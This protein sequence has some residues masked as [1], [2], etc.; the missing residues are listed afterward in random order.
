MPP[1]FN[2]S[3][4]LPLLPNPLSFTLDGNID[5]PSDNNSWSAGSQNFAIG[6]NTNIV[7]EVRPISE[8]SNLNVLP[9]PLD[10]AKRK[11]LPLWIRYA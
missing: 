9:Q 2:Q 5:N 6:L 1:N 4:K 8:S 3:N 7:E 10:A 11:T